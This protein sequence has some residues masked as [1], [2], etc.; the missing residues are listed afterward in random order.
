MRQIDQVGHTSGPQG[1]LHIERMNVNELKAT[2]AKQNRLQGLEMRESATLLKDTEELRDRKLAAAA[3]ER[4]RTHTFDHEATSNLVALASAEAKIV[5]NWDQVRAKLKPASS[6]ALLLAPL[7]S[8]PSKLRTE[9][10]NMKDQVKL[11]EKTEDNT[12]HE[13]VATTRHRKKIASRG[14]VQTNKQN[15]KH[16]DSLL[17]RVQ[18]QTAHT[19]SEMR[20][21]SSEL[22][23]DESHEVQGL[24]PVGQ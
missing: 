2:A 23:A 11:L 5:H 9:K 3:K 19:L 15:N 8:R 7:D 10:A 12:A 4:I 16:L 1:M 14:A 6:G 20:K 21:T 24:L 22:A 17:L 18:K 13:L